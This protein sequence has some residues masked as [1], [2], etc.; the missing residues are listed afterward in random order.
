MTTTIKIGAWMNELPRRK[1]FVLLR[2][3][4]RVMYNAT[5]S[6]RLR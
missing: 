1:I 2:L 4:W 6:G 5:L 3:S